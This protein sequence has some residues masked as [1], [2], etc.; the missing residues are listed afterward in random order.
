MKVDTVVPGAA[1]REHVGSAQSFSRAAAFYEDDEHGNVMA[2][3]TRVQSL[4]ALDAAF[5]PGDLVL[6]IG[7]GTGIEAVHLAR[8]GVRV[9]ATDAAPGMIEVLSAKL[10]PGGSAHDVVSEITP[11]VL[12]ASRLGELVEKYGAGAFDGCYSSMGPLNCEPDL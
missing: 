1:G 4:R 5:H 8:R 2:R 10:A 11:V 6:E 3:W 9:V 12:P 7:C